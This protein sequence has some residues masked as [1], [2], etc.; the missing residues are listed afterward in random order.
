MAEHNQPVF[1]AEGALDD[2]R[3]K[4]VPEAEE[5]KYQSLVAVP[6]ADKSGR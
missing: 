4:V 3:V 5:E 1:L 2:P 6:L